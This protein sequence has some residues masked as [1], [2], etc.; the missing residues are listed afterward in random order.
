MLIKCSV[1][2]CMNVCMH[3]CYVCVCNPCI[4]CLSVCM[5]VWLSGCLSTWLSVCLSVC[6]HYV[7][8]TVPL[9]SSHVIILFDKKRQAPH[10]LL[11][12]R[13]LL[14]QN[15]I[16]LSQNLG[17]MNR[18]QKINYPRVE[19]SW[20]PSSLM[21]GWCHQYQVSK[22]WGQQVNITPWWLSSG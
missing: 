10:R 3:L 13:G 12:H 19:I 14:A 5:P 2:Q 17:S 6:I 8:G 16:T 11:F 21:L 20:S 22:V 1:M 4:V 18:C 15:R 9:C 7:H